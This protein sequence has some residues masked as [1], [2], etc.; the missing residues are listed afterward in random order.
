MPESGVWACYGFSA[1][2]LMVSWLLPWN[3]IDSGNATSGKGSWSQFET[4]MWHALG[5]TIYSAGLGGFLHFLI[6]G[7]D[8]TLL[9]KFLSARIWDFFAKLS[10]AA[11]LWHFLFIMIVYETLES[12]LAVTR[13]VFIGFTFA[14]LFAAYATSFVSYIFVESPMA[15][16]SGFFFQP[17][18][19]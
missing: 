7:R 6:S 2:C 4:D 16:V 17:R 10:F 1:S 18:P 19:R 5:W 8:R 3:Y 14:V 11:Y 15:R 12:A 9:S 13:T